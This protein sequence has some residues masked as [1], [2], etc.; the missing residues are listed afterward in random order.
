MST[1]NAL[2]GQK[3]IQGELARL[4]F[5]VSARTVG[6]YM[7]ARR[8]RGPSPGWGEVLKRHAPDIWA[9][10]FFCVRTVLFQT[11]HVFFVIRHANREILHAEVTRHPT[12][13][14][15]A[16]QIV[17]C[18]AWD[19]APPRFLI[20]DRDSRSTGSAIVSISSGFLEDPHRS[21]GVRRVTW[22]IASRPPLLS[23]RTLQS[24]H[25]VAT[26]AQ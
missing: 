13:D 19:R 7:R 10:D 8:N 15:A 24:G 21:L 12:A 18:C 5:K 11:L 16:Q 23:R 9:C 22:N 6:K 25:R 1:E 4:G 17:E 20:H 2:W 14:W 3:R 26:G